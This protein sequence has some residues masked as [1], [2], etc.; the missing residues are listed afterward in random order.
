M[1]MGAWAE[2]EFPIELTCEISDEIWYFYLEEE[3]ENSWYM[4][5]ESN[6]EHIR[7]RDWKEYKNKQNRFKFLYEFRN[8]LISFRLGEKKISAPF[9]F[10]NRFTLRI[11]QGPHTEGLDG[12]CYK[13][14]KE[15]EKQI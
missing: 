12:Q 4:P 14:F 3:M 9:Y 10:I 8:N 2:D 6:P 11:R 13:G 1:S 7:G 15:Y 5:H